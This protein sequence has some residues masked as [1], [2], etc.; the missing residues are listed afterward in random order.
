MSCRPEHQPGLDRLKRDWVI[1]WTL[2]QR[3]GTYISVA[4]AY[5]LLRNVS[6]E[7]PMLQ[8]SPVK[9]SLEIT[10]KWLSY[11]SDGSNS[12]WLW[13][14]YL[15]IFAKS[16]DRLT[17]IRWKFQ[18][19]ISKWSWEIVTSC[20]AGARLTNWS[21][22]TEMRRSLHTRN[23]IYGA[24]FSTRKISHNTSGN[25]KTIVPSKILLQLIWL[26]NSWKWCFYW[27]IACYFIRSNLGWSGRQL[28]KLY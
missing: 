25:C 8:L 27:K 12:G 22:L 17:S 7:S 11:Q 14:I 24:V 10:L 3:S 6:F 16:P 4:L 28:T 19:R 2:F 13:S 9:I 5:I 26:R 20:P 21:Y 18:G 23:Y 1:T 15:K